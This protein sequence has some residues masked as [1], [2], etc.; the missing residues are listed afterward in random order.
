[1]HLYV[2]GE[3]MTSRPLEVLELS[4]SDALSIGHQHG[5]TYRD[6]IAEIA[7]LRLERI[8]AIPPYCRVKDVLSLA[9]EHIGLLQDFDVDLYL[10]FR[11]I[12]EGSNVSMERVVVLNHY[13]DLR[14]LVPNTKEDAKNLPEENGGCSIIYSPHAP[15]LGQTWDIHGSAEPYVV[16]L[17]IN[18]VMVFSITGCLGMTGMNR[19][20]VGIAINNLTSVDA[21]VGILWPALIRAALSKKSAVEAKDEVMSA[22]IGSGRHF[23]IADRNNFFSIETSGTKKKIIFDKNDQ[24][25]FH[26]NHCLDAEM[27]KTHIILKES[28]TMWRYQQLDEVVRH[29]DLSTKEQVFVAFAQV[30]LPPDPKEPHKTTTCGTMVMDLSKHSALACQGI[31]TEE[32]LAWGSTTHTFR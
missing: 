6:K 15:V 10:E 19:D 12:C 3:S 4:G 28:T 5:E 21:K 1:M 32:L 11:G 29:Q 7:E 27:R 16:L 14:D 24:L 2:K 9:H 20:G 30:S 26:T 17:K 8:C 25:Y 31:A 22:P 23:A 13:T 18:D